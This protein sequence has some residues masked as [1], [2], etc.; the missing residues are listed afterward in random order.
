MNASEVRI[1]EAWHEAL[2]G[3]DVDRLLALSHPD[4]EMGGP[5][6]TVRGAQVLREWV[7]RANIS[8]EPRHFFHDGGT[9]VV[10]G[11]AVWISPDNG[12]VTGDQPVGSVFVV[13]D[14]LVASVARY[15][16]LAGALSAANLD[17]SHETGP[18]PDP[19]PR[20]G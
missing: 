8:I 7:A 9:V 15:D 12:K 6:G 10:E 19:K 4:V 18:H 17:E 14:A 16:D 20:T 13:R 1:V 3:G 2:N 11:R 5:R